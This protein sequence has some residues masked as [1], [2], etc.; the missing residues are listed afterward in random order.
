MR[1]SLGLLVVGCLFSFNGANAQQA[2]SAPQRS[3]DNAKPPGKPLQ[4]DLDGIFKDFDKNQDGVLQRDE[5]PEDLRGSFER[6]DTN[7][8]G[9]IS[10]EELTN[11][12]AH[13]QPRR[14]A[15]DM[16]FVLIEM[17]DFD[18]ESEAEVRR[19][20]EILRRIDTNRD[21]TLDAD[22]LKAGREWIVK[23][24]VD[25][26]LSRLD[27][28]KDG[29]IARSEAKGQIREHFQDIDSNRDGFLERE[30]LMKAIAE[31]PTLT[32]QPTTAPKPAPV[33]R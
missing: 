26:L 17:S 33:D 10:R 9:K 22:E 6:L 12:I 21:G 20:Y 5:L 30:E 32:P 15:S 27:A 14:R 3:K 25:S 8:D 18:K 23:N 7:K 16:V 1:L 31:K 11:G 13:L 28:N 4:F 19:A 29:R 2:A 24:R